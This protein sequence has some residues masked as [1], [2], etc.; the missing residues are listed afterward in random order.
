MNHFGEFVEAE[1]RTL[2]HEDNIDQLVEAEW[3]A[4]FSMMY[5]FLPATDPPPIVQSACVGCGTTMY[6]ED[7]DM[8]VCKPCADSTRTGWFE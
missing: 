5:D 7:G 6:I 8:P 1:V 2:V 4:L 3:D